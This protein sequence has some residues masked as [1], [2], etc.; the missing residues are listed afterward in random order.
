M[1]AWTVLVPRIDTVWVSWIAAVT[2]GAEIDG[3][4]LIDVISALELAPSRFPTP[5][6]SR[7][8]CNWTSVPLIV[9]SVILIVSVTVAVVLASAPAPPAN[10]LATS[11]LALG[12]NCELARVASVSVPCLLSR[13]APETVIAELAVESI[14]ERPTAMA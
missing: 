8:D 4:K 9:E 14:R 12:R 1:A 7:P 13:A 5:L 2:L 3:P 11:R 6:L 10:A